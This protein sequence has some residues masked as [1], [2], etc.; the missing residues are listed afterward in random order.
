MRNTYGVDINHL[1][2]LQGY[3]DEMVFPPPGALPLAII[4]RTFGTNGN[5]FR[6]SFKNT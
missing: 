3:P 2:P 5:V 6:S 4:L 1:A